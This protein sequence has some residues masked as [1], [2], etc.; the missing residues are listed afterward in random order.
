MQ[1]FNGG[2]PRH[3][4]CRHKQSTGTAVAGAQHSEFMATQ[5]SSSSPPTS[6]QI[7]SAGKRKQR[8]KIAELGHQ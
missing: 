3:R 5:Q 8:R 1:H 2:S 7:R 4:M 6:R